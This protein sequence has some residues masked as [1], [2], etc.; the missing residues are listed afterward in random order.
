MSAMLEEDGMNNITYRIKR[1]ELDGS[2]TLVAYTDDAAEVGCI[3]DE[4]RHKI[5]W[6]AE[7]KVDKSEE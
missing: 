6:D 5:D 3:I 4:D 7:Y 2:W 1:Q